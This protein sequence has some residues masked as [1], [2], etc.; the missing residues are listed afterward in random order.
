MAANLA[1][2]NHELVVWNRSHEKVSLVCAAV[3][4]SIC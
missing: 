1:A 2:S 3:Q 4:H